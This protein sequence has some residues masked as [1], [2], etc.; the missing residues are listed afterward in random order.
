MHNKRILA[1]VEESRESE[2]ACRLAA[3]IADPSANLTLLHVD[4]LPGV[5]LAAPESGWFLPTLLHERRDRSFENFLNYLVADLD[6]PVELR[7]VIASD[8]PARRIMQFAGEEGMNLI[9]VSRS[10][11]LFGGLFGSI[12]DELCHDAPCPV[13]VDHGDLSQP[14]IARFERIIVG[15]DYSPSSQMCCALAARFLAPTGRME[16]LHVW[17]ELPRHRDMNGR[18]LSRQAEQ[19]TVETEILAAFASTIDFGWIE[20]VLTLVN[21]SSPARAICHHVQ[22][23]GADLVVLGS[24]HPQGIFER[25]LGT[26]TDRVLRHTDVPLLVVPVAAERRTDTTAPSS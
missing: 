21:D 6:H 16:L 5:A 26:V 15:V 12:T 20:P 24:H 18:N 11:S 4:S 10:P 7:E 25:A 1:P 23:S 3:A 17:D 2:H 8:S 9:V 22:N 19:A 13:L 14:P